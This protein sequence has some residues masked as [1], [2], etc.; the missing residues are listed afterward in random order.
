M[1]TLHG[2]MCTIIYYVN[3][4]VFLFLFLIFPLHFKES[5]EQ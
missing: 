2:K 5:S 4:L 1:K 3:Q